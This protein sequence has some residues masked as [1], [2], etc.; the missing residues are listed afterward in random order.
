MI[1]IAKY[2]IVIS[3]LVSF[4]FWLKLV[5]RE[6]KEFIILAILAGILALVLAKLSGKLFYDTRPFV[7][8]HFTP[9]FSHGADNGFPSDHT[10]LTSLLAFV[11]MK[12]DRRVG[13]ALL[14]IAVLVGLARVI[15]GVHHLVD[16]A[17]SIVIAGVSVLV[18]TLLM[19]II[20]RR[21][22]SN[23]PPQES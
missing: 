3:V 20:S 19:R 21:R 8:G 11:V 23:N 6:K 13:Y 22:I 2:F 16:I 9:Y 12:Y 18:V 1:I 10:L 15:A 14:V 4:V 5:N 17:G 7:A